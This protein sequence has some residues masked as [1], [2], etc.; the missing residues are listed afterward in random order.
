MQA[1]RVLLD[2]AFDKVLHGAADSEQLHL[3]ALM[4]KPSAKVFPTELLS[5]MRSCKAALLM[6]KDKPGTNYG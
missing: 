3:L 2:G 4:P 5:L 1:Q 6:F